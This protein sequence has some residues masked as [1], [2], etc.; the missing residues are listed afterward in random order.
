[1]ASVCIVYGNRYTKGFE[2]DASL[3]NRNH[4]EFVFECAGSGR[5]SIKDFLWRTDNGEGTGGNTVD[6]AASSLTRAQKKNLKTFDNIVNDH[7]TEMDF[8]G[9]LRD[10]QGNPVPKP[11]GGYW[12]H[13]QE[14]TNSYKTEKDSKSS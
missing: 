11:S 10:L 6:D 1:M 5:P 14:I 8:S 12:N 9:T 2:Y 3:F 4:N 7:L 13:L